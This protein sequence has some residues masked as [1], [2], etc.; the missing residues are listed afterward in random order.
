MFKSRLFRRIFGAY[1]VL[2]L[3]GAA[4][5]LWLVNGRLEAIVV[6]QLQRRLHDSAAVLRDDLREV[7]PDSMDAAALTK[8]RILAEQN[9][10][11]IT[12]VAEDGTVL[13]DSE[14]DAKSM[15]NHRGRDELLQ[16]RVG[17]QGVSQRRSTTVGI[18][19]MYFALPVK[20]DNRLVGFVRVAL[21]METVNSEVKSV[22]R[23]VWVT[24]LLV[25]LGA[26]AVTSLL[27]GRIIRP[28]S[29]LTQAAQAI[30]AGDL[31][32]SVPVVG[33]DEIGKLGEAFNT[34]SQQLAARIAELNEQHRQLEE[35]G[36]LLETVFGTMIE[37]VIAIDREQK[38]LFANPAARK[39]LDL[40]DENLDGKPVWEAIR[41]SGFDE[42]VDAVLKE[43]GHHQKELQIARSSSSVL[44][45]ASQLPG[46]PPAG[47]VLVLHDVTDLRKL[48]NLRR[49]FVSNVSHELKTPLTAIQA[50][51]DTLLEGGLDD[52]AHNRGFVEQ[53]AEAAERLHA[54]ILDLLALARIESDE[55]VFDIRSI[56]L[57]HVI[58]SCVREHA[59]VAEAKSIRLEAIA[60]NGSPRVLADAEGLRTILDN[61]VDNALNYTPPGGEVTV[62]YGVEEDTVRITVCDTGLGIP[63]EHVDRIFERFYRVDRARSRELGGT[64][65]GLSIVKHLVGVFNGTITVESEINE[66]TTFT[67]ALPPA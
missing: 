64:G 34:M 11:R 60:E 16:A 27:I 54:L 10:T 31:K 50:Y 4:V 39:L 59:G 5:F 57:Q 19:M 36:R 15:E 14:R 3:L 52:A 45:M 32:Q 63:K 47:A 12:L 55:Q 26:L 20:R 23:L 44:L 2:T 40:G 53:I 6:D 58:D 22:Q 66:G 7:F 51:A 9:K 37:A 33:S 8:V 28:V 18:P 43:G 30:A 24:T 38:I 67:V 41:S 42:T 48:E 35:S 17:E 13:A 61:L 29:D 1:V 21:P 65:L 49:D 62:N 56:D 46:D 25:G